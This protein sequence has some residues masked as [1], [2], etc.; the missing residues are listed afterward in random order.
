MELKST[1]SKHNKAA[2]VVSTLFNARTNA[3]F[4][5]LATGSYAQHKALDD[6]YNEIVDLG[7]RFAES[8]QGQYGIITGYNIG[9]LNT[10]PLN[11]LESGLKELMTVKSQFTDSHLVQILDDVTE[12][13][14]S[15]IYKL[16]FLK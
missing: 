1:F 2:R 8:Y 3:H 11:L 7:D 10:D 6:F 15:T 16:K 14:T 5:H 9:V 13:Y 12:L 4:A